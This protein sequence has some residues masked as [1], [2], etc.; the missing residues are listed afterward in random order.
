MKVLVVYDEELIRG[1]IK[2]Y[3]VLEGFEVDEASNG[4]VAVKL[5]SYNDYAFCKK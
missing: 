5:V 4:E 1:V 2:E 3:L